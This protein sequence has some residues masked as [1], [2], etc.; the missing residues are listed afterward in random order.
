MPGTFRLNRSSWAPGNAGGFLVVTAQ[1]CGVGGSAYRMVPP[2]PL[3]AATPLSKFSLRLLVFSLR[4]NAGGTFCFSLSRFSYV[5]FTFFL[6]VFSHSVP[7][8]IAAGT[9]FQF[10]GPANLPQ[11]FS[12]Q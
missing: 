6:P 12:F 4:L 3:W 2:A 10:G 1:A 8:Q 7:P 11:Q 5:F 9:Q